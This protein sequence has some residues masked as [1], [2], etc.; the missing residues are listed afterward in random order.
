MFAKPEINFEN[1]TSIEANDLIFL[2]PFK[3]QGTRQPHP[4]FVLENKLTNYKPII[5]LSN[6]CSR[7]GGVA[8]EYASKSFVDKDN[9]GIICIIITRPNRDGSFSNF[10]AAFATIRIES[11][12]IEVDSTL[13]PPQDILNIEVICSKKYT[14]LGQILWEYIKKLS[15]DYGIRI[16]HLDAVY[17]AIPTY[18]RWGFDYINWRIDDTGQK[19]GLN[20]E[21]EIPTEDE[22]DDNDTPMRYMVNRYEPSPTPPPGSSK[23]TPMNLGRPTEIANNTVLYGRFVSSHNEPED[24]IDNFVFNKQRSKTFGKLALSSSSKARNIRET[25]FAKAVMVTMEEPLTNMETVFE[26]KVP[27]NMSVAEALEFTQGKGTNKGMNKDDRKS[28]RK[29]QIVQLNKQIQKSKKHIREYKKK[30]RESMK[31]IRKS[32]KD[33]K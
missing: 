28:R 30:I 3:I 4:M 20:S 32:K 2:T 22:D 25:P 6:F 21:N 8:S 33:H 19:I 24:E 16:I 18:L 26:F 15:F 17:G 1:L 14:L 12:R 7:P 23:W 31:Q 5:G 10:L 29:R 11:E 9:S 27:E 13:L